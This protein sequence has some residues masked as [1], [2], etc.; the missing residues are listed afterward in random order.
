MGKMILGLKT[1]L[2]T[3][4]L[5]SLMATSSF[6]AQVT[7]E[8]AKSIAL[9]NAGVKEK[10]TS[11]ILAKSGREDNHPIFEVEFLTND[12]QKYEYEILVEDGIILEVGY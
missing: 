4:V 10:D 6:A 2:A 7:E 3:G 5:F 1:G 11:Y 12:F 8:K 9:E